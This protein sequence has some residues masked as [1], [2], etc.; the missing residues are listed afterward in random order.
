M[1]GKFVDRY[2]AWLGAICILLF[3]S[4]FDPVPFYNVDEGVLAAVAGII[5]DGGTPYSD[6]WCHRG[7][8]LHYIYSGLFILFGRGNM[9]AIHAATSVALALQALM[10]YHL[11]ALFLSK[12]T[13]L[14]ASLLFVFYSTFGFP[15]QSS[16]GAN[17][18]VWVNLFVLPGLLIFLSGCRDNRKSCFLW[19]GI[20][21]GLAV[22]TKQTAVF[23]YPWLLGMLLTGSL[24]G[25]AEGRPGLRSLAAGAGLLTAGLLAPLAAAAM[26]FALRGALGDFVAL[27]VAYNFFYIHSFWEQ[28]AASLVTAWTTAKG[29]IKTFL[30]PALP[31]FSLLLF[32]LTWF[33]IL[34]SR[35]IGRIRGRT[36]LG[37]DPALFLFHGW[38]LA[39]YLPLLILGRGFGNYFIPLLPA[40]AVVAAAVLT[41]AWPR[42]RIRG[43]TW[44]NGAAVAA[45][46]AFLIPP[47]HFLYDLPKT[48]ALALQPDLMVLS[49]MAREASGEEDRIF[50]WGWDSQFYTLAERAPAGRFVF[51]SFLTETTPGGQAAAPSASV[52][53]YRNAADL[54]LEDLVKHRPRVFIDGHLAFDFL[55]AYPLTRYP[56]VWEYLQNHYRVSRRFKSYTVYER[57]D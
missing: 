47:L 40:A 37:A 32:G 29:I 21:I 11:A 3:R 19:A 34:D 50:F 49:D 44:R 46:T 9:H 35:V 7:P 2:G 42:V 4:P 33:S 45:A 41:Q 28:D 25:K 20:G 15:A 53:G 22:L 36:I 24:R 38:F 5:L 55:R 57:I 31:Q 30:Y 51:C 1:T 16:L 10:L 6:G 39:Y 14:L 23:L 56:R 12:R 8:V 26:W 18:D 27:T 54:W 17:V 48:P 43:R 52:A 13:A